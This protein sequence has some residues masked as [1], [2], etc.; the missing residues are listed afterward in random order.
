MIFVLARAPQKV[1]PAEAL[2]LAYLQRNLTGT[3]GVR[4]DRQQSARNLLRD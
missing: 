1:P 3:A 4:K 2:N